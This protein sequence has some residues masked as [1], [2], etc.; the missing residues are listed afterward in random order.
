MSVWNNFIK[1]TFYNTFHGKRC[2]CCFKPYEF[3]NT[4]ICYQFGISDKEKFL[5]NSKPRRKNPL[6]PNGSC[7]GAHSDWWAP[8]VIRKT[9]YVGK[10]RD[11]ASVLCIEFTCMNCRNSKEIEIDLT[12][13]QQ[14]Y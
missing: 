12:N 14:T 3:K 6:S 7:I 2:S 8:F 5:V 10:E 11:L 13:I 1:S 9:K 4:N